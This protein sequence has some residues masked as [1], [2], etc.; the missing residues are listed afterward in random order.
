MTDL[1]SAL[2]HVL[3]IGGGTDTG[4]TSIAQA[5]AHRYGLQIYHYDRNEPSHI[6]RLI[7]AGSTYFQELVTK[8]A[9]GRWVLRDV[10]AYWVLR[11]P[12]VMAQ[13]TIASWKSRFPLVVEDLQA[14][15]KEPMIIAE[16]PGLFPENVYPTLHTPRQAIWLV[17]TEFFKRALVEQ[18]GKPSVR[19]Q[20]RDPERATEN[21]IGRDLLMARRVEE[22][23]LERGLTVCEVD[24]SRSLEEMVTVVERHFEPLLQE[25][26]E[27]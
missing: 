2:E 10:D 8:T 27:G 17:P 26:R 5:I 13:E 9:E 20:T 6:E 1:K 7:D 19:A 4:K 23:A 11:S 25:E 14:M 22:E 18:R 12:E 15:P 16:G 3:W 24:G 21:L